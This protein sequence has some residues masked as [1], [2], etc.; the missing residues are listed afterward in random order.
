MISMID[1]G[2]APLTLVGK[3][4]KKSEVILNSIEAIFSTNSMLFSRKF[5]AGE[6]PKEKLLPSNRLTWLYFQM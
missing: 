6:R 3:I 4:S 5:K 2:S 1:E